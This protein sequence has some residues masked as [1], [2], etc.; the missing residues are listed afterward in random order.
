MF[1][2]FIKKYHSFYKTC[3]DEI[4]PAM[5]PINMRLFILGGSNKRTLFSEITF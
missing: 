1:S 4:L 3:F 5:E 2:V